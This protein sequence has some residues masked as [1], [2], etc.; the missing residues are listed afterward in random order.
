MACNIEAFIS[1]V[2]SVVQVAMGYSNEY[3][4]DKIRVLQLPVNRGKGA[5]VQKVST[6]WTCCFYLLQVNF[7]LLL[8][9]QLIIYKALPF[10]SH[11]WCAS[12]SGHGGIFCQLAS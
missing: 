12:S 1:F 8:V 10:K 4:A 6:E 7:C 3:G 11:Q 9:K 2:I 5:A